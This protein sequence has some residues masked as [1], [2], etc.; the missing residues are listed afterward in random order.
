M[1]FDLHIL[2]S[3]LLTSASPHLFINILYLIKDHVSLIL[4]KHITNKSSTPPHMS[5]ESDDLDRFDRPDLITY[6][7]HK[8]DDITALPYLETSDLEADPT[9]PIVEPNNGKTL[10]PAL[11][12][13]IAIRKGVRSCTDHPISNIV[14]YN[15]L[16]PCLN[17][18]N[19]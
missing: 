1:G 10:D 2:F 9:S 13:P 15:A 4:F 6:Y 17:V 16:C 18:I 7:R 19:Y 14:C 11:N 8:D 5:I 12:L 3:S